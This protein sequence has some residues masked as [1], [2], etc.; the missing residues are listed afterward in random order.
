MNGQ[1]SHVR[2][3]TANGTSQGVPGAFVDQGFDSV[4][5]GKIGNTGFLERFLYWNRKVEC[6]NIGVVNGLE[7]S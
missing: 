5:V 1:S 6:P 3:M 7:P 4:K 2:W